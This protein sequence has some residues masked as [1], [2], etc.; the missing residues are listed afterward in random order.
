MTKAMTFLMMYMKI[1]TSYEDEVDIH[2]YVDT[3]PKYGPL[4]FCMS[5]CYSGKPIDGGRL[6]TKYCS[7][8]D[9]DDI[10]GSN[11]VVYIVN[12]HGLDDKVDVFSKDL[13]V[14]EFGVKLD[15]G[16]TI[17]KET[18][19]TIRKQIQGA[20][21]RSNIG[22]DVDKDN[23]NDGLE[24]EVEENKYN[25]DSNSFDDDYISSSFK[26]FEF[27]NEDEDEWIDNIYSSSGFFNRN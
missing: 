4:Q 23:D 20:T 8:Y 5:K 14:E 11:R 7:I 22:F 15:Y 1:L 2:L 9:D 19:G 13:V 25:Y 16:I 21:C 3:D 24:C 18:L 27:I 12:K 10:H 17:R 6:Q 26:E